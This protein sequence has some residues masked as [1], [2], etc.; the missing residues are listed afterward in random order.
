MR[1]F[2]GLML[3]LFLI[4]ITNAQNTFTTQVAQSSDDAEESE[5]T[6]SIYTESSD[7]ELVYDSYGNQNNQTVGIRFQNVN[8][9]ADATI[10]NAYIQFW[11]DETGD[12]PANL[13]IKGER[14]QNS[15]TFVPTTANIS[16]RTK[17]TAEVAWDNIPAWTT[18]HE[19][20]EDQRTPN[21]SS[22]VSEIITSND[23]AYGNAMT[24]IITGTGTRTAESYDG[25]TSEAPTLVIEYTTE[26]NATDMAVSMVAG[27][28]KYEYTQSDV[29]ISAKFLNNGTNA[30]D[31]FD[32]SY[33]L[34]NG[35]T[36]T[37]T[38]NTNV[39]AGETY[40]HTFATT[41]DLTTV[42]AHTLTIQVDATDDG[43]QFNNVLAY[44]FNV[45]EEISDVYF[46]IDS[47]W[48]YHDSG[49]DFGTVWTAQDFDDSTWKLGASHMGFG[50]DD[51]NV[52][53][54]AGHATYYFRKKVNIEDISAIS[55]ITMNLEADDAA[56]VYI[57]GQ[58]VIRSVNLPEGEIT[59]TTLASE[60]NTPDFENSYIQYKIDP[61]YF[62]TG[63]NTIAIEVHN[64]QLNNADLSFMC[65]I[66][67]SPINYTV[68]GP[69]VFRRDGQIIVKKITPNGP[70]INT[71]PE[72]SNPTITCD[73][74]NGDS[75]SF[76]LNETTEIPA[77]TYET[78]SKFFVTSDIEGQIDAL[79]FLLQNAGIIDSN[80]NWIYGDG[81]L[82]HIGDIF[83]RGLYVSQSIW[84][85]YKLEQE[86]KAA[87]GNVHFIVGN[88]E[89][90][91]LNYD[92]RY[93]Q[94]KYY[95]N[96]NSLGEMLEYLYEPDSELG[97]WIRSKNIIER[98]GNDAVFVHGG[99]SPAV[100]ALGLSYQEMNDY[101]RIG[102]DNSYCSDGN[103]DCQT[104]N[105]GSNIGLYWYRGIAN[106][107]VSQ[108]EVD[109]IMS[110]LGA[111]KMIFGH[112]VFS[113][114]GTLLYN[115][116]VITVDVD[117]G[118]N[119]YNGFM[120][121][122]HY[123]EGCYYRFVST[124][125][126]N[127]FTPLDPS[128]DNLATSEVD[129]INEIVVYPNPVKNQLQLRFDSE[130]N[131]SKVSVYNIAGK[132]I[133]TLTLYESGIT[134]I[135]TSHWEKGVYFIIINNGNQQI[136]KKIMK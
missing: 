58:E 101:G 86:A 28:D 132:L 97:A 4:G 62:Q 44:Q 54:I 68:D 111:D 130:W 13:I 105:G 73:L 78:P 59:S 125:S 103:T 99:V 123:N 2:Y 119:F 8:I 14:T 129:N 56:V 81:H 79:I 34:N 48:K 31:S 26:Q 63:L 12:G 46:W 25:T 90:M 53:L 69:Y 37:E 77:P 23:W 43:A 20:G 32:V 19:G 114:V 87:G 47:G 115:D 55:T 128:C 127:T 102:M 1:Q 131:N 83:D 30:I 33:T 84:L 5:S 108:S 124:F 118:E 98:A 65:S 49:E 75:F 7:L 61:S 52:V 121:A 45:V 27:L 93:V 100:A 106:Q 67:D 50:N 95:Q 64:V 11:V 16:A 41:V 10:T 15:Q 36:V 35:T 51:E 88:H 22:I 6:S 71:Y 29:A 74:P 40:T 76:N 21:L 112:S 92:F 104:I 60:V 107:L 122:L 82:Y 38:V 94:E 113:Q 117:H 72:D 9:P 80:Y 136:T 126:E 116:K 24:F 109:N 135:N 91:N 89:V 120:E 134:T 57:N 18:T 96:A 3:S 42:G 133:H 70:V 39:E 17:T 110:I 66:T 85:L